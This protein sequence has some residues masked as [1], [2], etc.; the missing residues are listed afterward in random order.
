MVA[1]LPGELSLEAPRGRRP[2]PPDTDFR[3]LAAGVGQAIGTLGAEIAA[4]HDDQAADAMLGFQADFQTRAAERAAAY[5]GTQPGFALGEADAW[6]REWRTFE[7]RLPRNQRRFARERADQ[8]KAAYVSQAIGVESQRRGGIVAE[9][10]R[11][12]DVTSLAGGQLAYGAKRNEIEAAYDAFD[13]ADPETFLLD[14]GARTEAALTA[15]R[16]AVPERLRPSYDA[17]A[18]QERVKEMAR[19]QAAVDDRQDGLLFRGVSD[20]VREATNQ[21]LDAPDRYEA[22]AEILNM[23]LDSLPAPV[24][25]KVAPGA[26]EELVVARLQG[27]SARGDREAA[28]RELAS[29]RYDRVLSPGT[30]A[31]LMASFER[32]SAESYTRKFDVED[33]A[34]SD[35]AE[36]LRTGKNPG[37]TTPQEV[38][39]EL[40]AARRAQYERDQRRA[41]ELHQKLGDL[42]QLSLRELDERVALAEPVQG[43]PSFAQDEKDHEIIVK[44]VAA[45]KQ[46]RLADPAAWAIQAPGEAGYP[47]QVEAT[48]KAWQEAETP[49]ERREAAQRYAR[50]TLKRQELAGIP[51]SQRRLLP[52]GEAA[53]WVARLAA[54]DPKAKAQAL[55]MVGVTLMDFGPYRGGFAAE[56]QAAGAKPA[57]IEAAMSAAESG[58]PAA[59]TSYAY[60]ASQAGAGKALDAAK[61]KRIKAE[62][63]RLLRPYLT[64]LDPLD[65]NR[66]RS[67]TVLESVMVDARGR[68]LRGTDPDEAVKEAFA[69]RYDRWEYRDG[70]RIPKSVTASDP[71]ARGRIV[72]GAGVTLRGVTGDDGKWLTPTRD[73]ATGRAAPPKAYAATVRQMGQWITLPDDTGVV[74][75]MPTTTGWYPVLDNR[76]NRII[77]RWDELDKRGRGGPRGFTP[78]P[79][80]SVF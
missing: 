36:A 28:K 63:E 47:R 64:S 79:G 26:R 16:E 39:Q 20:T 74:L 73:E 25:D 24:R 65:R 31:R 78:T 54:D 62:A 34:A 33:R 21:V 27:L 52:K 50:N 44:L 30:K 10:Q 45:E 1:R 18:A 72:A 17:W 42:P 67:Q 7:E 40:G 29:G 58:N 68:V 13:G 11:A 22:N 76:G 5:D 2:G 48:W 9:R 19:A 66:S 77:R 61:E 35:Y 46:R 69:V 8:A 55:E 23:A 37:N 15:G 53:G 49:Q 6:D 4:Y 60:G 75:M 3:A 71:G 70:I 43:T 80:G 14:V 41:A 32:E 59:F 57:D 51:P 56:L 12:V 38:E